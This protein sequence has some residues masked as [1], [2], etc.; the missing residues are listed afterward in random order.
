MNNFNL[1][2]GKR[3]KEKRISSGLTREQ[4]AG[5]ARISDKFLYDIEV[6]NKGMSAETLY[7]IKTALDVSA[8]WML[9]GD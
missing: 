2:I 7:R 1:E 3:I 8:D 9:M 4:L 5:M 6:G